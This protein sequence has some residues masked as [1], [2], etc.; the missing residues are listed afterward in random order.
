MLPL[1]SVFVV[2]LIALWTMGC[3]R[4]TIAVKRSSLALQ[5]A[6][7]SQESTLKLL[8]KLADQAQQSV[9]SKKIDQ[10]TSEEIQT[11]IAT[12]RAAIEANKQQLQRVLDDTETYARG[13]SKKR[14]KEVLMAANAAV[15]ESAEKLRILEK[16]TE[17]IVDFLGNET[18]SKS[19]IG[20]LFPPGGF[21]LIPAQVKEGQ[22]L[23]RPIVEK[24]F[25]FADKYKA[26]FNK[27]K[28]EIIVTGYSDATPVEPGTQLYQVLAQHLQKD[29]QVSEPTSSDLNQ[30][31]SEL[32]AKAVKG[33]LET[34]IQSRKQTGAIPLE[35]TVTVLGRGEEIPNGLT[36]DLARDDRR[37]R[38][39]TFYWVVLPDL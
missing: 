39:V 9:V 27:L 32:R 38:V 28:G 25:T 7:Q 26:G 31:L 1:K 8:D 16:K 15:M 29:N 6:M 17:V 4:N 5:T 30:K 33:L 34:I 35:I 3:S 10:S 12:E 18:F 21:Q 24:L 37:R 14:E 2:L 20:A 36:A 23:F 13:Q 19:E 11:Y 22:R